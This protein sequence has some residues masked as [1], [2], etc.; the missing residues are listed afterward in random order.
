M[1]KRMRW[2]FIGAAMAAFTAV[3]LTLLCTIN[4][5]NASAV[6]GRQDDALTRLAE[7]DWRAPQNDD[8]DQNRPFFEDWAHFSPEV[9]YSL[10]FFSVE[11]DADGALLQVNQD[12]IASVSESDAQAYAESALARGK[13]R[14]YVRAYR[15]LIQR[16]DN[17]TTVLFLNSERELQ[18]AHSLLLITILIAFVSLMIVFVLVMLF[19]R[20]A[21][22]PYLKNMEAQKQFIT[23]ASHEL[24]TPLTAISASADV[25]ALEYADNEWI[26]GIQ[27]QTARLAR[28][29]GNLVT[30]SRLNEENP[31]PVRAEFSLS[32]ALWEISEPF[33]SLA[34]AKGKRYSQSIEDGLSLTGDRTAVQQTVSILLD[35]ALKYSTDGGCIDL[36]AR[37]CGKRIE[38][39]VANAIPP[40]TKIDVS[41]LFDRF[42]RADESHSNAVNGSGVGLSIAKATVQAHGGRITASLAQ[43]IIT[44]RILL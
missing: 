26:R 43:D 9:R 6:A 33:T 5:W 21:I 28:L 19:S 14:G 25:L 12:N 3:V 39:A 35:N 8:Q 27:S 22:A 1:L 4:I 36:A 29:I 30:L 41:R 40:S 15:Y 42:Y 23:N 17:G 20:R 13:T 11:Y 34:R 24:K 2:R 7:A 32:D 31:F 16:T 38:I 44:F 18:A 10:R 37:R